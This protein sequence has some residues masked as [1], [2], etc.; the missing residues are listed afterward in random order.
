MFLGIEFHAICS[1]CRHNSD[2]KGHGKQTK[3]KNICQEANIFFYRQQ[4]VL[5]THLMT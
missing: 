1:K 3:Q 5:F 2:D 4:G